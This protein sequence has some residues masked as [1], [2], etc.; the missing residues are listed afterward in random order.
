[1]E[2]TA[3][4]LAAG[5]GTRMRS[6]LPKVLHPLAGRPM[7]QHCL[8]AVSGLVTQ[9][10][11]VVIGH[12]GEEVQAALGDAC[13]FVLQEEQLGTA[14]AVQTAEPI[15]KGSVDMVVVAHADL[16]LVLPETYHRLLEAQKT[17]PGPVS[18]L[19]V[20][21]PEARGFGRIQRSEDGTVTAIIEEAQASPEQLAINEL[22]VGAY[23][24]NAEWLWGALQRI[25][26]SLKGEYYLTDI[27]A[28]AA[29]E[30]K[31]IAAIPVLEVDE[32]VGINNRIHLAEAEAI[33]RRRINNRWMLAGVTLIDPPST[34]IEAEVEIG[35]DTVIYPNCHLLGETRIDEDCSIGPNT[36]IKDTIIGKRCTILASVLE[37]ALL[38]DDVDVGPFGRL[39]KDA[40]LA[41]GVHMG[42]FGEVKRSYL[43]PGTKMGHFSY[44][45]DAQIGANVNIGAG[46][47]TCNHDG[48]RKN[49]TEIGDNVF[50]GSD[51]M[52]VAPVKLGEGARTGAGAVVTKD[53]PPN[54]LVVGVPARPLHPVKDDDGD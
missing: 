17:N 52:L 35:P 22:N 26:L 6:A 18:L 3:V 16:P 23:C 28:L 13:R 39:R 53:V 45:G 14:N 42:N 54:T 1:M 2:V 41:N 5:Q 31:S 33:V 27:V 24:F 46:T 4:I 11:V 19:T 38:E 29:G 36:I 48:V 47:I 9:P 20:I 8:D 32:A 30:G 50:L 43:G 7:L 10:P 21:S 51:T 34:Y 25:A 12:K 37:G 40:H 49:R 44:I 15:L